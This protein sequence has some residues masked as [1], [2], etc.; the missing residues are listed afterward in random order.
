[1]KVCVEWREISSF[2]RRSGERFLGWDA[3]TAGEYPDDPYGGLCLV[4]WFEASD[5]YDEFWDIQP[6]S[7]N[8]ECL[9]SSA[10]VTH[11]A[12]LPRGPGRVPDFSPLT[13]W[14]ENLLRH[15]CGNSSLM[16]GR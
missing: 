7:E 2:P 12:E 5:G 11:W 4:T 13:T 3:G 6:F 1:M 10:E 16:P 9:M 15:W 8:L 14:G